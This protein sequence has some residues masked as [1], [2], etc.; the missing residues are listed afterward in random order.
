MR[1]K[2][3]SIDFYRAQRG[4]CEINQDTSKTGGLHKRITTRRMSIET[5]KIVV[6]NRSVH[7]PCQEAGMS[8]S[9]L[10]IGAC[11]H[12]V[13]RVRVSREE[14]RE[15]QVAESDSVRDPR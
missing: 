3:E 15:I 6:S 8:T 5:F 11:M 13:E 1:Q 2:S 10:S 9:S 12:R 4:C 14:C 7:A